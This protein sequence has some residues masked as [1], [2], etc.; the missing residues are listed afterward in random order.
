MPETAK[1]PEVGQMEGRGGAYAGAE[2]GG[3][4]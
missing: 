3:G 2:R 1:F 4:E